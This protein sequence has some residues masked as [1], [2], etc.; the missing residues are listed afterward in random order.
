[1]LGHVERRECL[2]RHKFVDER[3]A[4]M[5]EEVGQVHKKLSR[6]SYMAATTLVTVLGILVELVLSK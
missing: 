1:M 5:K 6:I 2:L 3:F 4:E